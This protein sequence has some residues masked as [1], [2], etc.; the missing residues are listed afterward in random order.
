MMP[1]SQPLPGCATKVADDRPPMPPAP[2][3]H[4]PLTPPEA[5]AFFADYFRQ[6]HFLEILPPAFR[7]HFVFIER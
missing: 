5:F 2:R 1:P 7:H 4:T 6:L 3:R